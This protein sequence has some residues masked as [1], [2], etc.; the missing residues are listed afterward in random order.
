LR[1][2]HQ[3]RARGSLG[4]IGRGHV[5]PFDERSELKPLTTRVKNSRINTKIREE[6]GRRRGPNLIEKGGRGGQR[7]QRG[8]PGA[9][10]TQDS[11]GVKNQK[12]TLY[13]S[14]SLFL[15]RGG[16][17]GGSGVV[18]GLILKTAIRSQGAPSEGGP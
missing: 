3:C 13:T 11:S 9:K 7:T 18:G 1:G 8:V 10:K 2:C 4:I 14:T 6:P 17:Q 5:R 16:G 15:R 12:K